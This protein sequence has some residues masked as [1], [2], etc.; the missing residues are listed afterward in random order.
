MKLGNRKL[1]PLLQLQMTGFG[2][3]TKQVVQVVVVF[4]L[5]FVSMSPVPPF[6]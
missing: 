3:G 2:C 4:V 1:E 6:P 5:V